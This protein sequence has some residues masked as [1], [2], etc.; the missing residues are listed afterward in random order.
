MKKYRVL[1]ELIGITIGCFI[2]AIGLVA[3]LIPNKIAA[4]GVSGLATVL[5]YLFKF[6]VGITMFVI[7][8]PLLLFCIKE[9]GMKFGVKSLYGTFVLSFFVDFLAFLIKEPW[10]NDAL[11][12]AVYGGVLCGLG[13]GVVFRFKGTTGG[14]DLA[15]ALIHKFARISLGYSLMSIDA[16]VIIL[17]GIVFDVE[18]A[19]YALVA[20]FVTSKMIDVVQEGVS[21]AK[22]AII[23]SEEY[24]K[25]GDELLARMERGVTFFQSKGAYTKKDRYVLL[26]VV[27]QSEVSTLKDIVYSID[28][29][30]F[31]IFS[32][33]HEVLGEGFKEGEVK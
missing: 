28:P 15:A 8:I 19:L 27:V 6:P 32:N 13:L 10:T 26:C 18:Q 16:M 4:G 21:Y 3:F 2:T 25:I 12:A 9:L 7:N 14:T 30:A 11:L 29:Q 1:W 17:A 5:Y 24:E 33:V 23:I 31:V 22:A 20:V